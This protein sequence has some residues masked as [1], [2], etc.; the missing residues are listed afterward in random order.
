MEIARLLH[1]I[2]SSVTYRRL[3]F[4]ILLMA[5]AFSV[6]LLMACNSEIEE[7]KEELV[8]EGWIADGE[9]PVVIVSSTLPI[10]SNDTSMDDLKD[11]VAQW[12]RVAITKEDGT[13]VFLTGQY[14][15]NY[16]PPY[17]FTTTAF[18]GQAGQRYH[19]TVDW[20]SH[21]AEASTIVPSSV[22][23]DAIWSEPCS[24]SDTLRQVMLRFCDRPDTHDYYLLFS[25][26]IHE[27]LNS[28]LCLFGILND[29]TLSSSEVVMSA[30][31]SGLIDEYQTYTPYYKVGGQVEVSLMH[32]DSITYHYWR[33]FSDSKQLGS[34]LLFNVTTPIEG[35]IV[36]G[37][38]V[39]YG[40]GQGKRSI[41]V[42]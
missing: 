2:L 25:R 40:C 8:V 10:S 38:G 32:V 41:I 7:K 36:G 14:D 5:N 3:A 34:F 11:Y 23:I 26:E 19:L 4:D 20:R 22:P 9:F 13:T 27:P 33:G 12:A 39:W 18:R 30:R 28:Q 35:N 31:R 21:H 42:Q 37:H 1:R 6:C 24:E 15:K 17:I 16:F 29:E